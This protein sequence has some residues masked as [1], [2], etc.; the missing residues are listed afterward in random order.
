MLNTLLFIGRPARGH[1]QGI[2]MVLAAI[3]VITIVLY[4]WKLPPFDAGLQQTDN[5]YVR[6]EPR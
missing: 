1:L 6:G 4:I 2:I 5:A 3:G